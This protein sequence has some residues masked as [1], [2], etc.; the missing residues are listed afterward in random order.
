MKHP[1][2][3]FC[4]LAFAMAGCT[5]TGPTGPAGAAGTNGTNGN[6]NVTTTIISLTP[7]QWIYNGY[8]GYYCNVAIDSIT[9]KAF[10]SGTVSVFYES[11]DG[12]WVGMPYYYVPPG[13]NYGII[14]GFDYGTG[15][16]QLTLQN[17][18]NTTLSFT[19]GETYKVTVIQ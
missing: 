10:D 15:V 4:L 8:G 7:A 16:I 5:K 19:T 11:N 12:D 2:L 6:A 17:T 18:Q 14:Y 13:E 9:S 3:C 1:I